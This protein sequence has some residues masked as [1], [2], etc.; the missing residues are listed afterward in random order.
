MIQ[1]LLLCSLHF[2]ELFLSLL[3]HAVDRLFQA[4]ILCIDDCLIECQQVSGLQ[5]LIARNLDVW[6]Y[7]G[8]FPVGFR[9]WTDRS[10]LR[11][12]S[13]KM[14]IE[15]SKPTRVS[16]AASG[17]TNNGRPLEVLQIV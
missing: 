9:D 2:I 4:L 6:L 10:A 12:E 16:T 5:G 14:V 13:S 3:D 17:F 11:D 1:R 8:S 7:S 15:P